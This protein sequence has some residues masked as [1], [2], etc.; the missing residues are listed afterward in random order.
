MTSTAV[1]SPTPMERVS[2][3][4][5]ET[6]RVPSSALWR[7]REASSPALRAPLISS[8]GSMPMRCRTRLAV[9]LRTTMTGRSTVV[10][11][12]RRGV[13]SPAARMG[14]DRVAFLGMSSP[15]TMEKALA[16]IRA[17]TT[18]APVATDWAIHALM[19]RVRSRAMASCM[20]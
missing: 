1:S 20:V 6:S 19:S 14:S 13:T 10:K 15:K 5:V 11:A 3:A 12:I 9:L 18:A 2:R 16:M 17:M 8:A 4:A 7:T